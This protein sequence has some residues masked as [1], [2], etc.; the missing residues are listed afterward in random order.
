MSVVWLKLISILC[1]SGTAL[2]RPVSSGVVWKDLGGSITIQCRPPG[3]GQE[4]L[5]LRKGLSEELEVFYRDG[6]S[7][8]NNVVDEF[9]DRL[10]SHGVFPNMD[11]LIKNLTSDDTGPYWCLYKKFD[12][13]TAVSVNMKGNG[14]VLLV[15]RDKL[16]QCDNQ[17]GDQLILVSL[18]ICSAVL[19]GITI[20]FLIWIVRKTKTYTTKKPRRV[21]NNEVY[22]DMR[23]TIRR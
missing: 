21:P 5:S 10:Q 1:L 15:V 2:S 6:A 4:Y 13:L 9:G 20:V 17:S 12:P 7:I 16:Q 14:S 19:F 23:G 22:E 11:I 18:V 3:P 8:K